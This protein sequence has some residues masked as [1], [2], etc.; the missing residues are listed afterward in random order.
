[1]TFCAALACLLAGCPTATT[2]PND[3][4]GNQSGEAPTLRILVVDDPVLSAA[5]ERE[6]SA[7]GGAPLE[8]T[9]ANAADIEKYVRLSADVAIFP[10][11]MLGVLAEK[12]LLTPIS[13]D[14]LNAARIDRQDMLPL[15]AA[16]APAWGGRLYGNSC[17]SPTMMLVFR[18]DV[19]EKLGRQPPNTWREYVELA[20]AIREAD[21]ALSGLV[22]VD[23]D[24]WLPAAEPLVAGWAGQ[25]LLSRAACYLRSPGQSSDVFDRDTMKPL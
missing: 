14:W 2:T 10:D 8:I 24:D 1:M 17:G 7:R 16:V 13:S 4:A 19:L 15:G 5:V 20:Q 6:W 25:M 9:N 12:K 23:D 3:G 18:R 21:Q 11:A 22:G